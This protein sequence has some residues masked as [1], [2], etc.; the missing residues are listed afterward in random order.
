MRIKKLWTAVLAAVFL[1][2][3]VVTTTDGASSAPDYTDDTNYRGFYGRFYVQSADIDVAL[4]LSNKQSVV[5]RKDS[6]AMFRLSYR[7]KVWIIAD[8]NTQS[9]A[10]MTDI[11][12]GDEGKIVKHDGGE[13]FL[14]C[15]EVLDGHNTGH[16]LTDNHGVNVVGSYP[17]VTYTC[18]GYWRNI[19]IC[20]WN[21]VEETFGEE[22]SA[23][24]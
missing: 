8:H 23:D 17:Y 15:A 18:I 7:P 6:A 12:V 4:Y 13:V 21:I 22:L 10:S 9:F 2:V 5:D 11:E 1:F 24:E 19:R 14:E 3:P 16:E 20:Q